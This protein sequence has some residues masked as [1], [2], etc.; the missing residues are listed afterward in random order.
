MLNN[1]ELS[2]TVDELAYECQRLLAHDHLWVRCNAAKLLA[3]IIGNYDF[4]LV[5]Y[6]MLNKEHK[7]SKLDFIYA[8][9]EADIKS[10][11]LDLC[12]QMVP[13]DTNP[14]MIEEMS[15]IFL[16]VANMIK[17]AP[18]KALNLKQDE[19]IKAAD[20]DEAEVTSKINLNW[21]MRN[22]RY[23]INKEVAKAPHCIAMVNF[24]FYIFINFILICYF[25]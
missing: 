21:L 15:K 14:V 17:E 6:N 2:A 10:L 18:F 12:A 8:N 16:F 9:P 3:L 25:L 23:L 7:C 11:V 24:L 1:E 4:E 19:D 13:G 22:I 5:G 20:N